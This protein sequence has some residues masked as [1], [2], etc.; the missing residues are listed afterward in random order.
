MDGYT[1]HHPRY[2]FLFNSYYNAVGPMHCRANRGAIS[3]PDVA[4]VLAYREA[5]DAAM[6]D[7]LDAVDGLPGEA[8]HRL[9]VGLNHEQ[10]HQEL[11]VTDLKYT[12]STNPLLPAYHELTT[13]HGGGHAAAC[14]G[15]RFRWRPGR[16][17]PGR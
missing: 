3:R 17:R 1:P 12:L 9:I 2:E 7:W 10:Q 16:N 5:V 11:M 13:A 8:R 6:L 15:S 14:N 4:E